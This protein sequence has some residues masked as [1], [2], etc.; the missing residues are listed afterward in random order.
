MLGWGLG[1]Q[2][3]IV[4]S[5]ARWNLRDSP[6]NISKKRIKQMLQYSVCKEFVAAAA[7]VWAKNVGKLN[8]K[9]FAFSWSWFEPPPSFQDRRRSDVR[10]WEE[11]S[12]VCL[13]ATPARWME[14]RGFVSRQGIPSS[15]SELQL[16]CVWFCAVWVEGWRSCRLPQLSMA[17]PS[18]WT[19]RS[20]RQPSRWRRR[21]RGQGARPRPD[22]RRPSSTF[23]SR[24][25]AWWCSWHSSRCSCAFAV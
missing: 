19:G 14:W 1:N 3:I 8:E 4:G 15:P 25:R 11:F 21:W 22:S 17:P 23:C 20:G 13:V 5:A 9:F 6:S 18:I 12:C 24:C 10:K 16:E 7:A 2:L